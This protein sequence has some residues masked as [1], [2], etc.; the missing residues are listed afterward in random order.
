MNRKSFIKNAFAAAAAFF[1]I[2]AAK[3]ATDSKLCQSC[4]ENSEEENHPILN[5]KVHIGFTIMGGTSVPWEL[6]DKGGGHSFLKW[7]IDDPKF[8]NQDGDFFVLG[9]EGTPEEV[10]LKIAR[11]AAMTATLRFDPATGMATTESI[12]ATH[13]LFRKLGL[14]CQ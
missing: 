11:V 12:R 1:G 13:R 4:S 5:E 3:A 10:V 8:K 9:S 2:G 14:T 6:V 7:K